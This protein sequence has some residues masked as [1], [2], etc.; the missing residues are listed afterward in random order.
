MKCQILAL[1]RQRQE[2][3]FLSL[4]PT[5][6]TIIARATQRNPVSEGEEEISHGVS[7]PYAREAEAGGW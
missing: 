4:R 3:L 7:P 2:N 6:S 1:R 5:W